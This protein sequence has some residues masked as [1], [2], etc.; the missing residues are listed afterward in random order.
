MLAEAVA[1]AVTVAN[2]VTRLRLAVLVEPAAVAMADH[3]RGMEPI[4]GL[5][6]E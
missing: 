6:Q 2:Q 3:L 5:A 4:V 1:V